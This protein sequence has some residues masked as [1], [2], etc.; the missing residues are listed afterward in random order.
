[1]IYTNVLRRQF[2]LLSKGR[3][4]IH[5]RSF[6][7][8]KL[9]N[10]E[11]VSLKKVFDDD[12]YWRNLRST[13]KLLN[14]KN[15]SFLNSASDPVTTKNTGLFNN[16]YLKTPEGLLTFSKASLWK[17]NELVKIM[18][19]DNTKQGLLKYIVR[20]DQ[21]SDTLCRVIDL[22][23]FIRSVHPDKEF[24]SAAQQ[25]HEE[26]FEFMNTL[27]TDVELCD[28]LKTLLHDNEIL[29][30]L[31]EEEIKVGRILLEDFEKSG[32]Y[33]N[34]RIREQFI[35][36][37]QEIS[38]IGQDFINNA[39]QP[40]TNY[41][42]VN[43]SKLESAGLN[44]LLLNSL[45]KDAIRENYKIPTYGPTP[46][47][48]LKDCKNEEVRA[49]IWTAL[50]SCS[51]E[52]IL[53]LSHLVKLRA[54]LANLMG[55]ESFSQYQ[56][57]G[58]LAKAPKDVKNFIET[59]IK[60]VRPNT[61]KELKFIADLKREDQGKINCGE[62]DGVLSTVRPWDRDYYSSIY[63]KGKEK[64][65]HEFTEPLS[66][67]FTLG[68]VFEG[69][70]DLLTQIYGIKL[71]PAIPVSGETWFNDVR[72]INV[73][74]E[75]EGIIGIIYFDLFERYGK[76]S[77]PAHFTVC[78]S[79]EMYPEENAD[80]IIQLGSKK[81]GTIFQLPIISLVCNFSRRTFQSDKTIC[82]LTLSEIETLFHEMGHAIHSML[83]RTTLQNVSGT[84]C[85]TDF[86][87]LPSILMEHFASD[88]RVLKKMSCH[89]ETGEKIAEKKLQFHLKEGEFLRSCETFSQAKMAM[90]DQ[91]LHSDKIIHN[92]DNLNVVE[93]YQNLE[94]R[95]QVLVDDRSN[96]C[97][98]FGHL[99]G[100]GATY[101]SYLFDRAI[102]RKVWNHLFANDPFNKTNGEKFKESLLKWGGSKDPWQCIAD[103]LDEPKLSKGDAEAMKYIG[104]T[105]QL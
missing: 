86:V 103:V 34:P 45:K 98:K 69:L 44:R 72:K 50:H 92:L 58:K 74:S 96:W 85:A 57:K 73:I 84:R 27:N 20:L 15:E 63:F 76:T 80:S 60:Y 48:V 38:L 6:T 56:L 77:N 51:S 14:S 59:L 99:F 29:S 64:T 3:G 24:L 75:E 18:K 10:H 54:M 88:T 23:E 81:D 32:I 39:N 100:Y 13:P 30:K 19:N 53:R 62:M 40:K 5:N 42:K 101:Y 95:L 79:R 83:G 9:R 87:E 49:D 68:G 1:M 91:E 82:L 61:E 7:T 36:L 26:M 105:E 12:V 52:Q 90:L 46:Y 70:S 4:L 97:G 89:Y 25:C 67:Y 104:F 102:A 94:R 41:I 78:C 37:S 8:S 71:E 33:M 47:A 17:A 65:E 11:P 93:I 21:L 16:P 55:A 22:C 43:A 31:S 2:G 35:E 28:K 66:S